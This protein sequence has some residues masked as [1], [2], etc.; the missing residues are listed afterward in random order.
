M[1]AATPL[2]QERRLVTAI[3]GPKSQELQARKLGAVAAGVG[4]TL[5]VYVSRANGGVL[6]DVDGNSLIDFG[7]GIAVTSV[8]NS[9][10][11]VVA[12]ATEQL[13]AFTHT[14]FMVT[15]YEGYVEVAEQL[16]ELTPG[17]HEKRTA[18]FNS[19]AEAVENAVKIARV[20][21]R[22]T[23]VVVFDHGYH[24]RTNLT[25]GL[26][27]KNMPYKQGFGPFAPEIYRVPVAYPYRWL[28][29]SENCAAEAAAQAIDMINKQI[30][31]EN[32]AAIIIEPIQGEGGFIEPAKGF[33]PAIVEYA[34]ANGIVFVADEIQTGFCRTG[35]WFACD[36]E[37]I[38]P[39]LITTAKGI[40]GG[41]PLAAVTGRAEIMD[42]THGGG[43]GG[44]YGG[45]PVAC[46]GALGAIETMRSQDLNGKAQRIGEIMLTRLRALQEKF[47]GSDRVNIGEVRGRGAMIAVELVKPGGKEPAAEITAAI[48]KAC[49]TEGLV[50]LTAG[51]YGNVLRFLPPL[52]MPEH[53]LNEGL[54]IIEGAF[55]RV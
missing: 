14:C 38:V 8:G 32:V 48:A 40:A 47:A 44:T 26:T 33:L 24:G 11:A 45:N 17:D 52:V 49:H 43:L 35:Q 3:P 37:G 25:M 41:L 29:G 4:T 55:S 42:A 46:A 23:A 19:G 36:D 1:S 12:K 16:N 28:T 51:T 39:D 50:V 6:E 5:P 30:G 53:L 20:Y 27:A 21:T 2:P 18:L 9:A 13:A 22:R 34:K 7:S 31:A 10:E 15:P 54:D